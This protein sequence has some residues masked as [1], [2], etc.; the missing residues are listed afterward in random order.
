MIR[1]V[2]TKAEYDAMPGWWHQANQILTQIRL[3]P[4]TYAG[5]AGILEH[6]TDAIG[7][8]SFMKFVQATD[9]MQRSDNP[10][11]RNAG[12]G[13]AHAY[14]FT[15]YKGATQRALAGSFG[16]EGVHFFRGLRAIN[17]ARRTKA[18]DLINT[19]LDQY[20]DVRKG[21]S[22]DDEAQL[23]QAIHDGSV[24]KLPPNLSMRAAK[25]K[26]V[27]DSLAHLSGT[28]GLQ[29]GLS[30]GGFELNPNLRRFEPETPRDLQGVGSYREH[31]VPTRHEA[32]SS[33]DSFG[34]ESILGL[35]QPATAEQRQIGSTSLRDLLHSD[36]PDPKTTSGVEREDPFLQ[37]RGA[38]GKMEETPLQRKII[39]A[40]IKSGAQAIAAHD[41]EQ[42]VAK[43]FGKAKWSQV[44]DEAKAYFQ[45]TWNEPDGKQF[46]LNFAK[47][48]IDVPKIGLFALPFRHSLNI[49]TLQALADPGALPGTLG[50][51]AYLM[52]IGTGSKRLSRL[53]GKAGAT[54]VSRF[55]D[56]AAAAARKTKA[57][58]KAAEYGLTG[59][60]SVDRRAA[61]GWLGKIPGIGDIYKASNHM[62]W[63]FDDAAKATR[64]NRLLRRYR[65]EG[66]DESHA[67]IR[68]ADQTGAELIDYSNNSP[69]TEALRY[70]APFATY[71]SKA[72]LAVVGSMLRHPERTLT[73]GRLSPELVGDVQQAMPDAQGKPRVGKSYLPLAETLRG[74]ENPL[75]FARST[76]GYPLSMAASLIG[77][78]VEHAAGVSAPDI[79]YF[80][81]Y[82]KDPDLKY[83]ANATIGSF[84]GGEAALGAMGLGEFANQ[85]S[86]SGA[87][88]G[89]T[90]FGLVR[91]PSKTQMALPA[92]LEQA[93]QQAAK[94]RG[95]G[96]STQADAI[97]KAVERVRERYRLYVP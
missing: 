3:D 6:L 87:V 89:Q 32:E 79:A 70:I 17:N 10:A 60:P 63:T 23:Y 88:R 28:E 21:L 82:G 12:Q 86:L 76:A 75:E 18:S 2:M 58:G 47:G 67:A 80:M 94:L 73:A 15:H 8:R 83:L 4:T 24:A 92:L 20:D 43:L 74:I 55:L 36:K 42:Q 57:L 54:K 44:P 14:D 5:G 13:L 78:G 9:A 50:R 93:Q 39:Q 45:E 59:S 35:D 22:R 46:W 38:Q 19:L 90:G 11:I 65:T 48:A 66:M 40:R 85:G 52:T 34:P 77:K 69:L 29:K 16:Q 68:A 27:T 61:S 53:A 7:T 72:P 64:F 1:P 91:G 31:Y 37:R 51:Y 41:A 26:Q 30:E 62:L 56:P 84:P 33:V 96:N 25:F 49:A 81:T 97:E 95:E 71:R